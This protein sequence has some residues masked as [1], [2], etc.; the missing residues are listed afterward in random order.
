MS[1]KS[2]S[3]QHTL[4]ERNLALVAQEVFSAPNPISRAGISQ[5][6]GLTRATVSALVDLLVDARIVAELS[7]TPPKGAGR[8]AVP[9]VPAAGTYFGIGLEV[10]V[11][12]LTG[13]IYDLTG[14]ELTRLEVSHT[15]GISPS[16]AIDILA[17]LATKLISQATALFP[18]VPGTAP[19]IAGVRLSLP[20]LVDPHSSTLRIAPNLGW[21]NLDPVDT[22][23]IAEAIHQATGQTVEVAIGNEAKFGAIAQT[24]N[25]ELA[26]FIYVSADVGIGSAIILDGQVFLGR[27]G[28]S[29]ELG[30]VTV[31]PAGS[32]CSCGSAGCLEQYAGRSA[33]FKAAGL[34]QDASFEDFQELLAS[35]SDLALKATERAGRALG[36][37]LSDY[38]N[39]IDIDT[40]VLGGIYAP[41]AG[42]LEPIIISYLKDKVLS[43]QWSDFTVTPA[44]V[45][46]GAST[47][48]GAHEVLRGVYED[49]A[50]WITQDTE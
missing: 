22:K 12:N 20:G 43:A 46:Q 44:P 10:T 36:R 17:Q 33:L 25:S 16:D 6:T 4:R 32:T 40:I 30:H 45:Q 7:P 47:R 26:T 1:V 18:A 3:G 49:P 14:T 8:P 50:R 48:G 21:Q 27:R 9:L 34:A 37:A 2:A 13:V 23:T 28:W 24:I 31:D 15:Y 41:L 5:L 42:H 35:G 39:L 11:T 19:L 29:G 38:I